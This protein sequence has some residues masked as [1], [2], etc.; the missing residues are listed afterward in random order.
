L[1]STIVDVTGEAVRILREGIIKKENMA[2]YS[3]PGLDCH[4]FRRGV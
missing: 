1:P 2:A 3:T 4:T